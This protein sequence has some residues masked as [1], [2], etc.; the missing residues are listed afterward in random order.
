MY[1]GADVNLPFSVAPDV[2]ESLTGR[3]VA[4]RYEVFELAGEGGMACVYRAR[5]RGAAGFS[6]WVALKKIKTEL[7]A[8]PHS[9]E[10]FVEEARVGAE[11]THPNLVQVLDFCEDTDGLFCL[12]TEWVEGIDLGTF[13]KTLRA[14][15][16]EM[17]WPLVV[18]MGIGLARGLSAAHE[19]V[20]AEGRPA[21]V[22]HRDISP[23]NVLLAQNGIVKLAD[24]GLS[25]AWDRLTSLTSPGIVKGKFSYLA[26][27]LLAG[28]PAS[29]TTDLFGFGAVLWEA[30][31]GRK[32]FEGDSD[33]EVLRKIK[34]LEIEPLGKARAKLPRKLLSII[35]KLLAPKPSARYPSAR[36]VASELASLLTKSEDKEGVGF[37][38]LLGRAVAE[39]RHL[40]KRAAA[41]V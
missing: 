28:A 34:A 16:R 38:R 33:R 18:V 25:R 22:I 37:D 27:E 9:L 32:L 8:M 14:N 30:L 29:E 2:S 35:D 15:G 10:M 19:R 3:L 12:V 23:P 6:R 41:R 36:V 17:P 20:D 24:F 7:R 39:A 13:V 1:D 4:G 11:L 26:P 40:G 31:A 5:V 21:G